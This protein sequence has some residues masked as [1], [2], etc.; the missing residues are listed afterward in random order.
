MTFNAIVATVMDRLN[1]TSSAATTRI[2]EYVNERYRE[3]TSGI[4]MITSRRGLTDIIVDATNIIAYPSL[5][6]IESTGFEKI[7]RI[8]L[9]ND[10]G[11]VRTLSQ[12]TY[13][14]ITNMTTNTELPHCW[15]VKTIGPSAVIFV[16]DSYPLTDPFTLRIEG[17][18]QSSTLSGTTEPNF[19]EDFHDILIHG[20][21]TDELKKMEKPQLA[22]I[23]ESKFNGRLSDLRMFIAK[24][25]YLDIA[26]GIDKPGQLWYRPWFSR[27][28]NYN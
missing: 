27:S 22:Q 25:A 2:G 12:K 11:R 16:L 6:E 9:L 3:V 18:V 10:G 13:D 26:Q 23:A 28:G 4:G 17:Y 14:D 24:S 5:P 1:L 7:L 21:M 20:A 19:P 8:L 15:A